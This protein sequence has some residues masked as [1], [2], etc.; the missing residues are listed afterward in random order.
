MAKD[1]NA[2]SLIWNLYYYKSQNTAILEHLIERFG[3]LINNE[4]GCA[5]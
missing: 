2:Y 1:I 5:T 4:L 3:L